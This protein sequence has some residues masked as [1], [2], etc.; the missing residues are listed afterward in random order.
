MSAF[1]ELFLITSFTSFPNHD[2]SV[3]ICSLGRITKQIN[4]FIYLICGMTWQWMCGFPFAKRAWTTAGG[5]DGE[6]RALCVQAAA[7]RQQASQTWGNIT[8]P[9][10]SPNPL[11]RTEWWPSERP[12]EDFKAKRFLTCTLINV[13][14]LFLWFVCYG[15]THALLLVSSIFSDCSF[16]A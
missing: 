8:D 3:F 1:I 4:C 9:G 13:S 6:Q 12:A 16:I 10:G 5:G 2:V 11:I 15:K 14:I 7:M